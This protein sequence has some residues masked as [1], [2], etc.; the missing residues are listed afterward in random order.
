[1]I[2]VQPRN[3]HRFKRVITFVFI[4]IL[5]V[6]NMSGFTANAATAACDYGVINYNEEYVCVTSKSASNHYA[7][8]SIAVYDEATDNY[9]ASSQNAGLLSNG[10]SLCTSI[11]GYNT[12][13]Y[14]IVINVMIYAGSTPS[15]PLAWSGSYRID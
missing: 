6:I 4:V 12:E 13:A 3:Y 8:V 1:M 15:S 2:T 5:S 7:I 10:E 9:V 11:N 14:Y